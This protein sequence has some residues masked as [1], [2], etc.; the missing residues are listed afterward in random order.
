METSLPFVREEVKRIRVRTEQELLCLR[1]GSEQ[2]DDP[3]ER[4][5]PQESE[6]LTVKREPGERLE[7]AIK[8]AGQEEF[9]FVGVK[10]EPAEDLEDNEFFPQEPECILE[11]KNEECID[12]VRTGELRPTQEPEC[13]IVQKEDPGEQP[14]ELD[15]TQV[16][17]NRVQQ[18]ALDLLG[19]DVREEE[20]ILGLVPEPEWVP[21]C[22]PAGEEAVRDPLAAEGDGVSASLTILFVV[23]SARWAASRIVI[24]A[25]YATNG[26]VVRYDAN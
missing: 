12:S 15:S 7:P 21:P 16:Q 6:R 2:P 17:E 1:L 25:P 4:P 8:S 23:L 11:Q 9:E 3:C 19:G 18:K 5:P 13:I 24:S 26:G 10:Q 20:E 22:V 14:G